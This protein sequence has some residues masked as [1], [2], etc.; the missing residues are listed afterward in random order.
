[1]KKS[2]EKK[3][4]KKRKSILFYV[5]DYEKIVALSKTKGD[6]ISG[7]INSLIEKEISNL[8]SIDTERYKK[9]LNNK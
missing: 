5:D 4:N 9:F 8:D 1:K 3:L 7:Y 6:T 2:D